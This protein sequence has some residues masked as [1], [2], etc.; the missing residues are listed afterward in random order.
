MKVPHCVLFSEY[1]CKGEGMPVL[2]S[3]L[4]LV[5][6]TEHDAFIG[7]KQWQMFLRHVHLSLNGRVSSGFCRLGHMLQNSFPEKLCN[8]RPVIPSHVTVEFCEYIVLI[9]ANG[10]IL[11]VNHKNPS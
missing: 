2:N 10:N 11:W 6:A 4:L 1:K 3:P 5:P 9:H 7:R 8:E